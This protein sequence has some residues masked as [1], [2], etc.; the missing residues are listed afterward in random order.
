MSGIRCVQCASLVFFFLPGRKQ[1]LLEGLGRLNKIEHSTGCYFLHLFTTSIG[2]ERLHCFHTHCFTV[3]LGA[4]STP[5][6]AS[7]AAS[8]R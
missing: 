4:A 8:G 6:P 5:G 7:P 3:Y 1:R 2:L